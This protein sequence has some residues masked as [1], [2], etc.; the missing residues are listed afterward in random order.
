[1][2]VLKQNL[3]NINEICGIIKAG[4][5]MIINLILNTKFE[6]QILEKTAILLSKPNLY[7]KLFIETI[8]EYFYIQIGDELKIIKNEQ[9]LLKTFENYAQIKENC[10]KIA[11]ICKISTFKIINFIEYEFFEKNL[12]D[13]L[14]FKEENLEKLLENKNFY[15]FFFRYSKIKRD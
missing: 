12:S 7:E 6:T 3:Q 8:C 5:K 9:K 4:L 11:Q 2:T 1:M 13:F 10:T 15:V 14:N